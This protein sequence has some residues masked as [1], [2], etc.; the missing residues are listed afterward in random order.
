MASAASGCPTSPRSSTS[1]AK[2]EFFVCLARAFQPMRTP[3][4]EDAFAHVLADDL[5]ELAA[6]AGYDIGDA[7]VRFAACAADPEV[8]LLTD[9]SALFLVPPV[10]VPLNAGL[11]LDG[12][13]LGQGTQAMLE[14]YR[15]VGLAPDERFRD[16]PDHVSMQLEYVAVMFA[17]AA[18]GDPACAVRANEFLARFVLRWIPAFSRALQAAAERIP[19]AHAYGALAAILDAA[20]RHETQPDSD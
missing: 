2:A 14:R 11:Y 16:L 3:E 5:L 17:R 13:L 10:P 20:A 1:G 4:A 6:E 12:G 19:A 9:Y 8:R 18:N 7:A 15:E